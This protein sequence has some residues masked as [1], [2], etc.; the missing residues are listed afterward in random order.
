[1]PSFYCIHDGYYKGVHDR[2][3]SLKSAC[4]YRNV[5]FIDVD[6]EYFDHSKLP[7]LNPDDMMYNVA[8]GGEVTESIFLRYDVKTFY[9]SNPSFMT[10][11]SDTVKYSLLHDNLGIPGPKTIF[12]TTNNEEL[13]KKYVLDL[14]GFP[15][16]LKTYGGTKGVGVVYISDFLTLK[17]MADLLTHQSEQFILRTYIPPKE[18]ARLKVI[19][20]RVVASNSKA[21]PKD[22]FRSSV[23]NQLPEPK[24]YSSAIQ[25]LAVTA[26]HSANLMNC[27][28]DILIDHEEKAYVLEVNMPHDF[29][30]TEKATGID[31][32]G[33]MIDFILQ[34]N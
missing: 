22:D 32:A 34:R 25:Q 2:I 28:V 20:D 14:G 10:N 1:M 7:N 11:N 27:G 21:I 29:T 17:S 24:I 5:E 23:Q 15:L 13:L 6:C 33:P 26:A 12:H 31:L 19:G 18:I 16:I 8:R 30:T 9:V 3:T 4:E